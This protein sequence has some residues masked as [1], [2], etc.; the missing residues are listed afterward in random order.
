MEMIAGV[1]ADVA[2]R[3]KISTHFHSAKFNS[4]LIID[5]KEIT[6]KLRICLNVSSQLE[7]I[8]DSYCGVEVFIPPYSVIECCSK[9]VFKTYIRNLPA[10]VLYNIWPFE[11]ETNIE[12]YKKIIKIEPETYA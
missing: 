7:W 4:R 2:M 3:I 10:I 1:N 9:E 11:A 6:K 8:I 5:T 12:P